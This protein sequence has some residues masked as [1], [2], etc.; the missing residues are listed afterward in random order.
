MAKLGFWTNTN[1]IDK[2]QNPSEGVLKVFFREISGV[3]SM[4]IIN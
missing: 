2:K 4:A 1:D 3:Y